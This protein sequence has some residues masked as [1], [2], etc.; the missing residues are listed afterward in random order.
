MECVRDQDSRI[1]P[2]NQDFKIYSKKKI[3]GSVLN[4]ERS[5]RSVGLKNSYTEGN[6]SY[7]FRTHPVGWKN[8]TKCLKRVRVAESG[9]DRVLN[10]RFLVLQDA[11]YEGCTNNKVSSRIRA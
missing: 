9:Q 7:R 2:D 3:P 4:A 6:P 11:G 5:L 10:L 1:K 8:P